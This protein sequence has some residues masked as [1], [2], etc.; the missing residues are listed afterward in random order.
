MIQIKYSNQLDSLAA[1]MKIIKNDTSFK[2]LCEDLIK[3]MLI[4]EPNKRISHFDVKNHPSFW[5]AKH[6]AEFII[7]TA[8]L[9]EKDAKYFEFLTTNGNF[10]I[11]SDWTENIEEI[12]MKVIREIRQISKKKFGC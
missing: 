4:F 8:I 10:V 5:T 1:R 9:I 7:D 11:D 3:K 6:S 2:I 12:V